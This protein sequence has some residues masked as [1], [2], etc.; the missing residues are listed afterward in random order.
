MAIDVKM[1]EMYSGMC[2]RSDVNQQ[3]QLVLDPLSNWQPVQPV[4][5]CLRVNHS[6]TNRNFLLNIKN[7]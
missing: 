4:N 1:S 2:P 3:A 7:L 6:H 5:I